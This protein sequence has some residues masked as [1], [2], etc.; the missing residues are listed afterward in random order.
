MPHTFDNINGFECPT[1]HRSKLAAMR[2]LIE[3]RATINKTFGT[4][5]FRGRLLYV[6]GRYTCYI[7]R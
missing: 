7:Y 4:D 5:E 1:R 2:H 6:N 3:T